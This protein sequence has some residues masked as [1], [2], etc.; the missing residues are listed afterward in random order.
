M[1]SAGG[2]ST[3]VSR[4]SPTH[5]QMP[6]SYEALL[7]QKDIAEERLYRLWHAQ[8]SDRPRSPFGRNVCMYV[9]TCVCMCVCM[10]V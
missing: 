4:G 3:G 8:R 9:C 2:V 5:F 6:P 7:N 10:Y 1:T